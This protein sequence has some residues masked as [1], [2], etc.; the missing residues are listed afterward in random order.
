M[1][2]TEASALGLAGG[3]ETEALAFL[4]SGASALVKAGFRP[5]VI[6]AAGIQFAANLTRLLEPGLVG[7]FTVDAKGQGVVT[8]AYAAALRALDELREVT[9]EPDRTS[10]PQVV[11][12]LPEGTTDG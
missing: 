3:T 10:Y 6:V 4:A 1:T 9:K 11:G 7:R 5:E 2:L 8:E 12:S